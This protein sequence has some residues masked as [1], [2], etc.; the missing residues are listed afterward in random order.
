[1]LPSPLPVGPQS[2]LFWWTSA[3]LSRGEG[4]KKMCKFHLWSLRNARIVW[5][6]LHHHAPFFPSHVHGLHMLAYNVLPFHRTI[7][8]W[9]SE[10]G[11]P[12]SSL[13]QQISKIL[14]LDS[15][16]P[17]FQQNSSSFFHTWFRVPI[18]T[19]TPN[20]SLPNGPSVFGVPS[21]LIQLPLTGSATST[22]SWEAQTA[23]RVKGRENESMTGVIMGVS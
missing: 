20:L 6:E 7:P 10:I 16:A 2:H 19:Q 1:M 12:V 15:L 8:C 11:F 14:G 9:F 21:T 23:E 5:N 22:F 13:N 17:Y 4:F 3:Q 18:E